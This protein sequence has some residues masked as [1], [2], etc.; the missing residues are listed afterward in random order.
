VPSVFH[1]IANEDESFVGQD[2]VLIGILLAK[3]RNI[4]R[5]VKNI[6]NDYLTILKMEAASSSGTSAIN[7][8]S[9]RRHNSKGFYPCFTFSISFHIIISI[10]D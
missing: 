1:S 7:Y 4:F 6:K 5:G 2:A 3:F 9:I 8:Q 10:K